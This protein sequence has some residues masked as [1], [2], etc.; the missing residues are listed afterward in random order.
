MRK[1]FRMK[2]ESCNGE[3]YDHSDVM[4][5]RTLGLDV[6]GAVH[7]IRR[8]I[9]MHRPSCGNDQ[10]AFR[11]DVSDKFDIFIASFE[12]Y[13]ALDLFEG[14]TALEAMDAMIDAVLAYYKTDEY[15]KLVAERPGVGHTMCRHGEDDKLVHFA[16]DFS[17]LGAVDRFRLKDHFQLGG[18]K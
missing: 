9:E 14:K 10:L 16:I 7:F 13:G 2:Y 8:L 17:G 11:L 5:I 1:I 18:S 3:C 12:H 4:K 6:Q 15:K